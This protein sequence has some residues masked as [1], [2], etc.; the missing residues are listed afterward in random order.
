MHGS[1]QQALRG[2]DRECMGLSA[3]LEGGHPMSG[4]SLSSIAATIQPYLQVSVDLALAK[5]PDAGSVG[6]AAA[7]LAPELAASELVNALPSPATGEAQTVGSIINT[8]A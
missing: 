4:I 6:A 2:V 1:A 8:Y 3:R 7:T 5:S